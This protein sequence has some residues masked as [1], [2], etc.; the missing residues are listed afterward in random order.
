MVAAVGDLWR[1]ALG[2]APIVTGTAEQVEARGFLQGNCA[3]CH[4]PAG[5]LGGAIDFRFGTAEADIG[6]IDVTPSVIR[7]PDAG[8]EFDF[9]V[10]PGDPDHS[11]IVW[12]VQEHRMPPVGVT[13]MNEEGVAA[14]QAWI[15][16][17]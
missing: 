5:V 7:N 15:S 8:H 6:I 13:T 14:L 12:E 4:H 11:T 2:P 9:I 16:A 10:T 17:M 1:T 3:H